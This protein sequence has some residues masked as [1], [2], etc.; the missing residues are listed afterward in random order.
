MR[1]L[2]LFVFYDKDGIVDEYVEY[3][4]SDLK[5]VVSELIIIV[6]G[7]VN[8]EGENIL[9][10]YSNQYYTRENVGFDAGAYADVIVNILGEHKLSQYDELV[11]CNDTFYGPFVSFENIFDA[12]RNE[13]CDFWGL[14]CIKRNFLSYIIMYFCVFRGEMLRNGDLFNYFRDKIL[15]KINDISD[16]FA[17]F[18]VGVYYT[19]T[20]KRY[21]AGTYTYSNEYLSRR[22]PDKCL[23]KYNLPIWKKKFFYEGNYDRLISNKL[24]DYL[25]KNK[26]YNINLISDN[27][28]RIYKRNILEQE[29]NDVAKLAYK[30]ELKY[31]VPQITKDDINKFL[32]KNTQVYIY[33]IGAFAKSTAFVFR[34]NIREFCGFIISDEKSCEYTDV[35]GYPVMKASKVPNNSAIIVALN[36]EHSKEVFTRL[37]KGGNIFYF[38]NLED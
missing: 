37:G 15:N 22:N 12:M 36:Y 6:N 20:Q 29:H 3:L 34:D 10:K 1:R 35:W 13:K 4:I 25:Q 32:S 27:V 19:L 24:L 23:L 8:V 7:K 11:L 5:R 26:L 14:D 38:W 31:S 28:K 18:Q 30:S 16:A 17:I 2:G 33:G 9:Q 21:V